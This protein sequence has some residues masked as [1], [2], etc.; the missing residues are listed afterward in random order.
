MAVQKIKLFNQIEV[1][2]WFAYA[3]ITLIIAMTFICLLG[4]G[5]KKK[6]D[7]HYRLFNR[8]APNGEKQQ[9]TLLRL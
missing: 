8:I 9:R 4:K 5:Q 6:G 1:S 3:F 2:E 7:G